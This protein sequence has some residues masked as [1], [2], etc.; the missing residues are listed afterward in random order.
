MEIKQ[1]IHTVNYRSVLLAGFLGFLVLAASGA[2]AGEQP[3]LEMPIHCTPGQDCWLVNY[4]DMD[5]TEGVRDYACGK[6]SYDGH[7]GIDIAIVD[8]AAMRDGVPV[9]AAAAGIVRGARN[10]MEDIDFN[11]NG[12]RESV[13]DKECGNGALIDHGGGW[14][15]QYCHMLKGSVVV[16]PGDKVTSGRQ[17]GLV[18]LSGLTEFPHVHIQVRYKGKIVD[19]FAG[20]DR[21]KDCGVGKNPLW[22][23][24]ALD[25][26]PYQPTAIYNAGFSSTTPNSRFA[27]EGLYGEELLLDTSPVIALWA[28]MFWVKAGDKVSFLIVGPDGRSLVGHTSVLKKSQA[29]RFVFAGLRR[30][31]KAWVKGTYTGEI[32]LTRPGTNEEFSV[33]RVI[34]VR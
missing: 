17:L 18:G 33:T 28:D 1:L 19:P 29:R 32:R 11:Q 10:N 22:N 27:R 3:K 8:A 31:E 21:T 14:E 12:G 26:M 7:K 4:V 34:D 9:Y 16:R 15:T 5:P 13:A 2:L 25:A 30:Q 20:I 24:S 23:A 6:A